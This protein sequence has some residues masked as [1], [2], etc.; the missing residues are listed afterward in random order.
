MK[1]FEESITSSKFWACLPQSIKTTLFVF[2]ETTSIILLVKISHP[3]PLWELALSF[4]TVNTVLS[5]N[6]PWSA[7]GCKFPDFGKGIFK[8]DSSSLKI[9]IKD[10]GKGIPLLTLNDKPFA[11]P[12]PWYGSCPKIT[13]L[14][15]FN[16]V[17]FKALNTIEALG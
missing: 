12:S 17:E 8:S 1:C 3:R 13:T 16:G 10:G 2:E 15:L 5:S 6:T 4:S 7:Q 14:I 11:C 9:F